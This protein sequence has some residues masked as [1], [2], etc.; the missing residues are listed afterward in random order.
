M[1]CGLVMS[2]LVVI[3]YGTMLRAILVFSQRPWVAVFSLARSNAE[4]LGTFPRLRFSMLMEA[5]SVTP[6]AQAL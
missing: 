4:P 2:G 3:N 1:L 5:I 6:V